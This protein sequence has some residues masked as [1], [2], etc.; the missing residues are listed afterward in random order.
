MAVGVHIAG[1]VGVRA[2]DEGAPAEDIEA[3]PVILE[4][5]RSE[6]SVGEPASGDGGAARN[7]AGIGREIVELGR[8]DGLYRGRQAHRSRVDGEAPGV[9]IPD[10]GAHADPRSQELLDEE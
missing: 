2:G 7:S 1:R 5:E 8:V 6:G 3:T 4:V 9:F 10:E